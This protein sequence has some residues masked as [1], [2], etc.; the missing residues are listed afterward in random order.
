MGEG[1]RRYMGD[2]S[3]SSQGQSRRGLLSPLA[4]PTMALD[5]NIL[6]AR[7][8]GLESGL[9]IFLCLLR[10]ENGPAGQWPEKPETLAML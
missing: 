2:P 10:T 4:R 9:L 3:S 1:T 8:L 5:F 7:S 6:I